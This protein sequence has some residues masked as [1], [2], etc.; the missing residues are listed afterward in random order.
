MAVSLQRRRRAPSQIA[1]VHDFDLSREP[2][3]ER[4]VRLG[5]FLAIAGV[6]VQ[7][8]AHL[9]YALLFDYD[10]PQLNL[11]AEANVF[12][13]ASTVATFAAATA[14]L[15]LAVAGTRPLRYS[16]LA[17]ALALF[18][19]DDA[20]EIH[21]RLGE[22]VTQRT[23]GLPESVAYSVWPLAFFPVLALAFA[24]LALA[25]RESAGR[26]R[27]TLGVGLGL[28]VTGIGVEAVQ[29]AW[30]G[31]G[32]GAES[33]PGALLIT[34]EESAE[35]AGWILVASGLLAVGCTTL[36]RLGA[37]GADRPAARR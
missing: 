6:G 5:F 37:R 7:V 15:L 28:L 35:L 4:L 16:F 12:S 13:W 36:L 26:I 20:V 1:H 24:S 22:S 17:G 19:L 18:S 29:A 23:L 8:V 10:V 34:L 2:I 9:S 33:V 27:S 3:A 32:E 11:D 14:A 25:Y 21:E 31:T 30:Y